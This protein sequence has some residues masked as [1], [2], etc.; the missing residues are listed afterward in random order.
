MWPVFRLLKKKVIASTSRTPGILETR[1][2]K[3]GYVDADALLAQLEQDM[4]KK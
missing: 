3:D 1:F 4:L 2:T